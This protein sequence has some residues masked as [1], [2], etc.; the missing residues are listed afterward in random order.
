VPLMDN[1]NVNVNYSP[2]Q[3]LCNEDQQRLK[4]DSR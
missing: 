2:D 3:G 1:A 4:F